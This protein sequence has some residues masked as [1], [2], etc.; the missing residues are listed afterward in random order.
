MGRLK[1][2]NRDSKINPDSKNRGSRLKERLKLR[3]EIAKH[4]K[5]SLICLAII[6]IIV[7]LI[8]KL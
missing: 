1:F 8:S 4:R 3:L 6:T 2:R 7:F 5:W